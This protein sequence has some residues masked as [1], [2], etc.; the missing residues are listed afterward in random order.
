MNLKPPITRTRRSGWLGQ[1]SARVK[2]LVVVGAL[3]L[4]IGGAVLTAAV[5]ASADPSFQFVEVGSDTTEYVMDVFANALGGSILASY[6]AVNPLTQIANE[7][8]TPE[9]ASQTVSGAGQNCSFT[10][11]NGSGGGYKALSYANTVTATGST[12][13]G[14]VTTLGQN[15]TAPQANCITLDRSSSPPGSVS[16]TAGTP[17]SSE[18]TGAGTAGTAAGNFVYVP[19]AVDALTYA[20]GPATPTSE[21]IQCVGALDTT[22]TCTGVGS[23]GIGT[24]T[25][26]TA[27]TPNL[28]GLNLSLAQL[29]TLYGQCQP[30]TVGTT[31]LN[32]GTNTS[33]TT[34]A[35][36]T[37]ATAGTPIVL[38]YTSGFSLS[39][40]QEVTFQGGGL[41]G[42]NSPAALSAT[43]VYYVSATGL[44]STTFEVST[45]SGGTPVNYPAFGPTASSGLDAVITGSVATVGTVDLYAPQAGSGTLAFWELTFNLTAPA[46]CWHQVVVSGP[47]I[48]ISVEEHDGTAIASDP[49]GIDPFSIGRWVSGSTG[50]TTDLRHGAVLED[51]TA[52]GANVT[53]TPGT[54]DVFT[55]ATAQ[56][57]TNGT[58][59]TLSGT[60]LPGG[61]TAGTTYFMVDAS[62]TFELSATSGGTA[63]GGSGAGTAVQFNDIVTPLNSGNTENVQGC[64]S[65]A[66]FNQ[67]NCFVLTREL[68]NVMDYYQ[69]VNVTP[70]A[71]ITNVQ[72]YNSLLAGE[73]VGG[74]SGL[75]RATFTIENQGFYPI[76]SGSAFSDACGATTNA[77]RV[78]ENNSAANG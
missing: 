60:T 68:F 55:P 10:R 2:A 37:S 26:T 44:T 78:Q 58:E 56:T 65:G 39:A 4:G 38:N 53:V 13:V 1:R 23:N 69:V 59:V 71:G 6:D 25:F 72:P 3:G 24:T 19:F 67:A 5:P 48:G 31:T 16:A 30:V 50:A 21:T 52:A 45:T 27:G 42:G 74:S 62:S 61:F 32:P 8:V 20:T 57:F 47:A 75:C 76:T 9:I 41:A 73:F 15:G 33:I 28:Q 49:I 43:N 51:M 17:G 70:P 12:N 66:S 54:A 63:I 11:P 64:L 18:T 77:L 36:E 29:T 34:S 46:A 22:S 14:P 7:T 40:N 35:A